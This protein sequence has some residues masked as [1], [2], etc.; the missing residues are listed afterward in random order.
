MKNINN[1]AEDNNSKYLENIY[2]YNP[3]ELDDIFI[4]K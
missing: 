1:N 3:N 4:K 2:N